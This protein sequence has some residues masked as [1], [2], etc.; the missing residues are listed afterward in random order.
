MARFA[1]TARTVPAR[2]ESIGTVVDGE[3]L[4]ITD[5]PVPEFVNGRVVGPKRDVSGEV[6]MQAD[7]VLDVNGVQTLVHTRGGVEFAIA[8]EL[9]KIGAD[10]LRVGDYLSITYTDTEDMGESLDP[11]KVYEVKIVPGGKRA[12]K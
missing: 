10:D 8:R 2:F 11:A 4:S 6:I 9:Q 3:V 7:V 12:K 5:V 1:Q